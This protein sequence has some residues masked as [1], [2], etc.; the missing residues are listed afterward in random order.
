M[1]TII[2]VYCNRKSFFIIM[3]IMILGFLIVM[4]NDDPNHDV[5]VYFNSQQVVHDPNHHVHLVFVFLQGDIMIVVVVLFMFAYAI[6]N[7]FFKDNNK[8]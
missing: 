4:V 1:V 8:M 3:V 5:N 7:K 2:M 6:A